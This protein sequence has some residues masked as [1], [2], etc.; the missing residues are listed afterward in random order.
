MSKMKML[1]LFAIMVVA[2]AFASCAGGGNDAQDSGTDNF[3]ADTPVREPVTEEG[4]ELFDDESDESLPVDQNK[5]LWGRPVRGV[6]NGN[7]W[8]SEYIGLYFYLPQGW[9]HASD[10]EIVDL[11]G[12]G[13]AVLELSD[14]GMAV[15]DELWEMIDDHVLHDM[16][17]IDLEQGSNIQVIIE[18]LPVLDIGIAE[19][20]MHSADLLSQIGANVSRDLAPRQIGGLEWVG[21]EAYMDL[22]GFRQNMSYF[23]KVVDGFAILILVTTFDDDGGAVD[24][25]LRFFGPIDNA[26]RPS[27]YP[28]GSIMSGEMMRLP[29]LEQPYANHPLIGTWAWDMDSGFV[30]NF[31]A[32]GSGTRGFPGAIDSFTWDVSDDH[33]VMRLALMDESWT[34]TIDG[35][36]LRIDSRQVPGM[37]WSYIR[38]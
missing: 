8:L 5:A 10:E 31:L 34:F 23:M 27:W 25:Y 29:E 17:A 30:Y 35:N 38:Q 3:R 15:P 18:R 33:L 28:V 13:T 16:M 37:S 6:W 21:F 9:E 1:L 24:N 26:P 12:L 19:F 11:V 22:L 7:I 36:V 4:D 32:D 20:F 14:A 2:L